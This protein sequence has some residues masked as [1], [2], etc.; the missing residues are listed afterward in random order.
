MKKI[1]ILNQPIW[2]FFFY[3]LLILIVELLSFLHTTYNPLLTYNP[4]A[5]ARPEEPPSTRS[6]AGA[7]GRNQARK[8][9]AKIVEPKKKWPCPNLCFSGCCAT[10]CHAQSA[11]S[12]TDYQHQQR[13]ARAMEFLGKQQAPSSSAGAINILD[14]PLQRPGEPPVVSLSAFSFLLSEM[15]QYNQ[16]RWVLSA[17]FHV[18]SMGEGFQNRSRDASFPRGFASQ[19]NGAS[20]RI[21]KV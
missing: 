11:H 1:P 12:R 18:G 6:V 5:A 14:R 10:L 3:T 16:N 13:E 17:V 21:Y 2:S 4:W 8:V 19:R 20:Q 9:V 7:Q 15:I